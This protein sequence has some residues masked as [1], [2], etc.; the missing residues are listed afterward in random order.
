MYTNIPWWRVLL[1]CGT[2]LTGLTALAQPV[3]NFTADKTSGCAPLA[4]NFTNTTSGASATAAYA[5]DF[6]NARTSA[7]KDASSIFS[8]EQ[9]YEVKLTVTDGGVVSVKTMKIT[10]YK[11]PTV[12]FTFQPGKACAPLTVNFTGT[13]TPYDGATITSYLWDYGDGTTQTGVIN[14]VHTYTAKQNA[15]VTLA[16][17][18][19]HGCSATE[20]KSN[21]IEVG[22][23]VKAAFTPDKNMLC[24]LNEKIAFTNKTTGPGTLTYKW[25]FGDGG[26][27]TEVAPVHA[28]TTSGT[29]KPVLTVTSSEG[30][31]N[32][33]ELTTGIQ[34]GNIVAD[35]T[36]PSLICTN[37]PT[38][39]T[40]VTTPVPDYT[41]WSYSD[42]GS[43]NNRTFTTAGE[44]DV[45]MTAYYASCQVPVTK[46]VMVTQS[47]PLRGYASENNGVCGAPATITFTDTSKTALTWDWIID[48][49]SAGSTKTVSKL[50][51]NNGVHFVKLTISD[52][53]GCSTQLSSSYY[54]AQPDA[55]IFPTSST[56]PNVLSGCEGLTASFASS[57]TDKITSFSWDFGDGGKSTEAKPTHTYSKAGVYT[58]S[59]IYVN[60]KGCEGKAYIYNVAIYAKPGIDFT[61]KEANPICG[62]NVVHFE[63]KA[64]NSADLWYWFYEGNYKKVSYGSMQGSYQYSKEGTYS[65]ILIAAN[66]TC[67]DTVAKPDLIKV[68]PP[69]V[70]MGKITNSCAGSRGMATFRDT[71][72][73]VTAWHWDFGDGGTMTYTTAT[74]VITHNYTKTGVYKVVLT[75]TAGQCS[76]RDSDFAYIFLKQHPTLTVGAT[77]ACSSDS[78]YVEVSNEEENPAGP[79]YEG[80]FR[81]YWQNGPGSYTPVKGATPYDWVTT[82]KSTIQWLPT[83]TDS[84]RAI[85]YTSY[86]GCND[87]TD[88]VKVHIKGPLVDFTTPSS[89]VCYN[90]P[91]IFTD[92]TVVDDN[93]AL[94]SWV[95]D[96]GDTTTETVTSKQEMKHIYANPGEHRVKLRATDVNGCYGID[97]MDVNTTGPKADFNWTPDVVKPGTTVSFINT[98]N[99]YNST[100]RYTWSFS[101]N[102]DGATTTNGRQ[103]YGRTGIDTVTLIARNPNSNCVDSITKYVYIKNIQAAFTV[104][105]VY[106]N[107]NNCPPVLASFTNSSV[108]ATRI[109][110]DFGDGATA[111]DVTTPTHTYT[112]PG[113]YI[114]KLY[115]YDNT[116]DVDSTTR[117]VIVKGPVGSFT[118]NKSQ[119]CGV[120][121]TVTFSATTSDVTD[122]TWDLADGTLIHSKEYTIT[123]T[124]DKPGAYTPAIIVKNDKGCEATFELAVP[125]VIDTLHVM[126]AKSAGIICDSGMVTFSPKVVNIGADQLQ[127]PLTWHWNFGTGNAA[128]TANTAAPSFF[129]NKTGKYFVYASVIS[130]AGCVGEITDSVEV[131]DK[132]RGTIAGPAMICMQETA[133]FTGTANGDTE[134]WSWRLGEGNATPSTKT[135]THTYLQPGEYKVLLLL[136]NAGCTDTAVH[137]LTVHALPDIALQP[138]KTALL[139]LGD[140]LTLAAHDGVSYSW[141]PAT[142]ISD[143]AV[144]SPRVYPLTNTTYT[145]QVTDEYGCVNKDSVK[146]ELAYPFTVSLLDTSVCRGLSVRLMASGADSYRWI[147]GNNLDNT[148]IGNPVANPSATN[149]YTVVGY[150]KEGCFTDTAKAVITVHDVPEIS[151]IED[152]VLLAGTSV[153]LITISSSNVSNYRWSPSRYLD[154]ADCA[155]PLSTPRSG[156]SYVVTALTQFGCESKDTVNIRL[157]CE[158]SS[159]FIPNTFT[160]N[161]DGRNDLFYPRGKGIRLVKY[162]KIYNR[163][164]ELVFERMNFNVNDAAQGWNGTFNGN[165]INNSIFNYVTEMVCDGGDTFLYKGTVQLMH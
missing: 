48:G 85:T 108:N 66:G 135:V 62:N 76:V 10:V 143:A 29:F 26:T 50:F 75:G 164:G 114:A 129:Y 6:G 152:T 25:D 96:Y 104:K 127:L 90:T 107:G 94:V 87:T 5:W 165:A 144:S 154:C 74:P 131:K 161:K 117:E 11:K 47:P 100:A 86:F 23:P 103:T 53:T 56:S 84:L 32:S 65:V 70:Y 120:P 132:T 44:F 118:A 40:S 33:Y 82:F 81:P 149:S 16:V 109:S 125:F 4:I 59:L 130:A 73:Q 110:W 126:P 139:C 122:F 97:S 153:P 145:V 92:K 155:S 30:C 21:A 20:I 134:Q 1:V 112:K 34:V 91:N 163:L 146:V 138:G 113:T 99:L 83:G 61:V 93:A 42:G 15:T 72:R 128:D 101:F 140:T 162:F 123:H 14:A 151:T 89:S 67:R 150:D 133:S 52:A 136:S 13:V 7:N 57:S 64:T 27:S 39:F 24:T 141:L 78:L 68:I 116:G 156:I 77:E 158:Q 71:S 119:W 17:T 2:L 43:G 45:T 60:E 58:I 8:A 38:T 80:D 148:T 111:G 9:E 22:Q 105:T 124:Y 37:A 36:V 157:R 159:V 28:Y 142:A 69:F 12:N 79:F 88:F 121:A 106:V 54:L 51:T 160:P 19:S 95:W 115:A 35:F 63:A 137:T 41:S 18:D 102:K 55:F 3:A 31:G 98:S 49:I 147:E 46:K